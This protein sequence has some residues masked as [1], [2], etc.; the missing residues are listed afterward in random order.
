MS[1]IKRVFLIVVDSMGCGQAPDADRFGD[2]GACTLATIRKSK[3]WSCPNLERLGLFDITGFKRGQKYYYVPGGCDCGEP[4][5]MSDCGESTPAGVYGRLTECSAGKD[6]TAGHWEIAGLI[7]PHS[8]PAFPDGFPDEIINEFE[9]Q[10]GR[11]VL[12]NKPYSGTEVIKDYGEEHLKTGALIVYTSADSVF[13]IAAHE[14]IVPPEE[15]YRYCRIA[16]SILKGPKYGVGRVIARPFTGTSAD[17]FERVNAHRHDFSIV[18]PK[19]T[20]L[21]LMQQAGLASIGIG[22][23][24]DIFAGKGIDEALTAPSVSNVDGMEKTIALLKEDFTGLCFVNLVETDSVY[25]HRRDVD[26]YARAVS[27]FDRQLGELM[28]GMTDS[29]VVMVTADHGCDPGFKGTDHTR[30]YIPFVAYG[31]ALNGNVDIGTR[32]CFGDIG[33]TILD[34]FGISQH[35]I[36]GESFMELIIKEE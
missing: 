8:F 31:S 15:L 18:P 3:E 12:C 34:I 26:G 30:E 17:N 10:T 28:A 11:K 35:N 2:E 6:T 1:L 32:K 14:E 21:D 4:D 36:D 24:R 23:I 19:D 9:R 29:D 33:A 22:K 13:Q 27:T 20:A 7:T 16:R 25:G 5:D